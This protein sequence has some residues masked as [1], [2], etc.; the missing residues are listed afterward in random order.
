[1]DTKIVIFGCGKLGHEALNVLGSEKVECFCDNNPTLIGTEQYGKSVISFDKLREM[2]SDAAVIICANVRFGNAWTMAEQCEENGIWDYFFWQTVRGKEFFQNE[3]QLLQYLNSSI[4]RKQLKSEVYMQRG[5]ELQEQ[6]AYLKRHIDIRHMKPA[7][8]TLRERQLMLIRMAAELFDK[9][10]ELDIRPFLFAG[11]LLGYVR[12]NGFIPW[13]DD[14]DFAL[15]RNEYERL[16][17]FC[18]LHMYAE[19][20]FDDWENCD[21]DVREELR[22][23]YWTNGG[24]DEFNICQKLPDGSKVSID[25][26]VLDYYASD[27]T[28]EALMQKRE[29]VKLRLNN[30]ISEKAG[31]AL[32]DDAKR[33]KCF[34]EA[35]TEMRTNLAEESEN[36]YFGIDCMNLYFNFHRGRWIPRDVV[37]PLKKV[38]YEG[39]YFYVPNDAEE[40]SKYQY[41]NIW[42]LPADIGIP[43]HIGNILTGKKDW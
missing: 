31:G 23:Y 22:E 25:F 38:L 39:A 19:E 29:E 17:E 35:L 32:Y 37:F 24:G 5:E 10:K 20:E 27:Y 33:I 15:M 13:D 21:K 34:Q 43:Q 14:I 1:M 18:R 30:A 7:G 4:N 40:F 6:L 8:G 36:I 42:E 16:Q 26:F 2:Y 28:Y 11:N 12:H 3:A 9:L 41:E